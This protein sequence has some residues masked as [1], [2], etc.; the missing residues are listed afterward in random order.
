MAMGTEGK[1]EGGSGRE[2]GI[3]KG[4]GG[5]DLDICPRAPS[6]YSYATGD[7]YHHCSYTTWVCDIS[8]RV[9]KNLTTLSLCKPTSNSDSR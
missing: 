9:G 7:E 8:A 4:E 2:E 6:S 5:L 1:R 3:G